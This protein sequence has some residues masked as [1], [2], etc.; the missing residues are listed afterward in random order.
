MHWLDAYLN[1]WILGEARHT[2]TTGSVSLFHSRAMFPSV[3]TLA[4]SENMLFPAVLALPFGSTN[5]LL[6]HHVVILISQIATA[7][8][9]WLWLRKRGLH[10][11]PAIFGSLLFAYAPFRLATI[12]K[13]HLVA[14]MFIPL[15]LLALTQ[16][17]EKPS[18]KRTAS[19][20]II[21]LVQMGTR[22]YYAVYLF[23]VMVGR[24]AM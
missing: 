22:L 16:F 21:A 17:L 2:L 7:V 10:I 9:M 8:C 20:V 18:T 11:L 15:C 23:L 4:F 6:V 13:L 24:Y 19:L 14:A 3:G 5:P 1:S 12:V